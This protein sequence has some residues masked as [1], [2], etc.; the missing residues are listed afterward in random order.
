MS[1]YES[2]SHMFGDGMPRGNKNAGYIGLMIAKA[3]G[4]KPS[5]YPNGRKKKSGKFNLNKM[6][7]PSTYLR[8]MFVHQIK[9]PKTAKAKAPTAVAQPDNSWAGIKAKYPDIKRAVQEFAKA[10]PTMS[11]RA[12]AKETGVSQPSVNR[13]KKLSFVGSGKADEPD[14]ETKGMMGRL[15]KENQPTPLVTRIQANQ[16]NTRSDR[17][18][19]QAREIGSRAV[20]VKPDVDRLLGI[21]G[22]WEAERDKLHDMVV[23][24]D[25][26]RPREEDDGDP[27]A[28]RGKS[29]LLALKQ[30]YFKAI[31]IITQIKRAIVKLIMTEPSDEPSGERPRLRAEIDPSGEFDEQKNYVEHVDEGDEPKEGGNRIVDYAQQYE[32]RPVRGGAKPIKQLYLNGKPYSGKYHIMADGAVHTGIKHGKRSKLLEVK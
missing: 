15:A 31:H 1:E 3:K 25:A 10:N 5:D 7:N 14:E 11:E 26:D 20:S 6:N 9:K 29:R 8:D 27:T 21:M 4:M 28:V 18:A 24:M 17:D 23:A 30:D 19:R 2:D 22:R 13:Y 12:I 16:L 32:R